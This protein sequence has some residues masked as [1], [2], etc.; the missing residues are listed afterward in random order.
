MPLISL[1]QWSQ[2]LGIKNEEV[3]KLCWIPVFIVITRAPSSSFSL[4]S[5]PTFYRILVQ[6]TYNDILTLSSCMD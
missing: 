6:Q 3:L 5:K 1:P 4:S 2:N